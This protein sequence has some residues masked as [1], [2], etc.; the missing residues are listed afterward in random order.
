MFGFLVRLMRGCRDLFGSKTRFEAEMDDELVYHLERVIQE[1]IESGMTPAEARRAAHVSFG[2]VTQIKEE[3]RDTR[4]MRLAR[5]AVQDLRYALRLLAKSPGFAAVSI[6]TLALGIGANTAIFSLV[7]AIFLKNLAVPHPEELVIV[8]AFHGEEGR[9]FSYP[10]FRDIAAGQQV[11]SGIYASGGA[12]F[13][14]ISVEGIGELPS[15]EAVQGRFVSRD[16]FST[17]GVNPAPGRAFGQDDQEAV[18]SYG[19][20]QKQLGKDRSVL[21]RV[22]TLNQASFVIVGVAPR[23]F[24]GESPGNPVDLWI[25]IDSQPRIE[26]RD[27]LEV[28]TAT[29]FRTIARLKPDVGLRQAEAA[30]TALYRRLL[31]DEIASG[32]GSLIHKAPNP[33]EARIALS[34]G[35][36]GFSWHRGRLSQP[37]WLLTLVVVLVLLIACFNL[38]NLL[39]A[40]ASFRQREIG[41][42]L[43][44][45][46]GRLRLIRQLLTESL[47]LAVLGGAAGFCLFFL[48]RGIL[49]TLAS[50][51]LDLRPDWRILV[52]TAGVA[53]VTGVIFGLVPALQATRLQAVPSA[54]HSVGARASRILLPHLLVTGQMA[55]SVV[56]LVGAGLLVRTLQNLHEFNPGF[57]SENVLLFELKHEDTTGQG[58]TGILPEQVLERLNALPGVRSAGLS[59]ASFFSGSMNT[60]P[61]RVPDSRVN[62]DADAELRTER[63][64]AGYLDTV[65]MRLLMGRQLNPGDRN[66]AIINSR[67]AKR[68]FP[69]ENP[70]GK[71]IY[72]PR[73]DEQRRYVP[74][75]SN[76]EMEQAVEIVGVVGDAKYDDLR[77][78]TPCMAY[79]PLTPGPTAGCSVVLRAATE[80]GNLIEPIRASL[81]QLN[82][83]LSVGGTRT[84]EQQ[85]GETLNGERLMT[86]LLSFFGLLALALACM[87]LYGLMSYSVARRTREIGVRMAL[88][89]R[90]SHAVGLVFKQTLLLTLGGV[91]IGLPLALVA[92]RLVEHFLFGVKRSDPGVLAAAVGFLI[93]MAALASYLPAWRASRIEPAVALREE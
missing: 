22:I 38:A 24:S 10:M 72:F 40:R 7:D 1:N 27:L 86:Q 44:L 70:L 59:G 85:V 82:P 69:T 28:R 49:L 15:A 19:F 57:D 77:Q 92:T 21:G 71:L 66:V 88:G 26:Q 29:W 37:L 30:L 87:G 74:F 65:G 34:P 54:P 60:S 61:V 25:P 63:V 80:P 8:E 35:G 64:S 56:L 41:I 68:Y 48:T 17:L 33:E 4:P 32:T 11:F 52:F 5:E 39:L 3:C 93:L 83:S 51:Q 43:A 81:R 6:L 67:M 18:I 58:V 79:L 78:A 90:R 84:L 13:S 62:P 42:R 20:W 12:E 31:A 55:L 9:N 2:G 73:L 91:L 47:L 76:L 53:T 16:Y 50:V 14:R 75:S 89:A 45:G 23:E 36:K 46:A